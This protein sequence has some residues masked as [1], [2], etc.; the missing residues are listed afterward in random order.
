MH[1][2]YVCMRLCCAPIAGSCCQW[3][4]TGREESTQ[5]QVGHLYNEDHADSVFDIMTKPTLPLSVMQNANRAANVNTLCGHKGLRCAANAM[6]LLADIVNLLWLSWGRNDLLSI[7]CSCVASLGQ[8]WHMT[9]AHQSAIRF[10]ISGH[11]PL[12]QSIKLPIPF[13]NTD[14]GVAPCVPSKTWCHSLKTCG[15][16]SD[17][18][19]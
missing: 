6:L 18:F 1:L 9:L 8:G 14:N 12:Q 10:N 3:P 17:D 11:E 13:A 7:S 19:G 15:L 16:E 5:C 4:S 2:I